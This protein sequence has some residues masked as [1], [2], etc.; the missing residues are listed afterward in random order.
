MRIMLPHPDVERHPGAGRWLFENHR[1]RLAF[2]RLERLVMCFQ[3][4]LH[5]DAGGEHVAQ[6]FGRELAEIEKMAQSFGHCP[7]A[8]RFN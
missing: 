1:Q 6:L 5:G 7:A 3:L 2:E 8:A 4:R